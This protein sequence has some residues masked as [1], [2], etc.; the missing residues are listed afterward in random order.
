MS[1]SALRKSGLEAGKVDGLFG[2]AGR[3]G[4]G[5]EIKYELAAGEIGQR[6]SFRRRPGA[7]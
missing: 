5:I 3:V 7:G 1:V 2:A 4:P 6:D